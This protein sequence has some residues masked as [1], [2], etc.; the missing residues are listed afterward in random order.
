[1]SPAQAAHSRRTGRRGEIE[2]VVDFSQVERLAFVLLDQGESGVIDECIEVR[3]PPGGK[4]STLRR[5]APGQGG[6]SQR[7]APRKPEA[8]VTRTR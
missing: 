5:G 2:Q 8:P 3:D 7:R 4:L 6:A 1:M